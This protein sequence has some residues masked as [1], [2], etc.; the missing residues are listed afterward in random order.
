MPDRQLLSLAQFCRMSLPLP[1]LTTLERLGIHELMSLGPEWMGDMENAPWLELLRSFVAVKDLALSRFMVR[2]VA[3]A[4]R[5]L[6]GEGVTEVLPA[7][8]HVFVDGFNTSGRTQ[9]V[10]E[11]FVTARQLSG[12]P[13][14]VHRVAKGS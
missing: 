6:T 7:L 10:I 14:T 9:D 11:Q 2:K 8:R 1:H 12:H 4:L 13:V 3:P 5:E